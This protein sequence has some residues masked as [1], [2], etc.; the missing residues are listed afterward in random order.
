MT[1]P[2]TN[3]EPTDSKTS[4]QP[5]SIADA[6]KKPL[7]AFALLFA[8][9]AVFGQLVPKLIFP[10]A[11]PLQAERNIQTE[12]PVTTLTAAPPP[13]PPP[14]APPPPHH[15]GDTHHPVGKLHARIDKL[16]AQL[17]AYEELLTAMPTPSEMNNELVASDARIVALEKKLEGL[18]QQISQNAVRS[19]ELI[20]AFATLSKMR[21]AAMNGEKF[22]PQY[23]RFMELN[24]TNSSIQNM[25]L[26]LS[27]YTEGGVPTLEQLQTSF[28]K[29]VPKALSPH[30]PT[31]VM[32][33]LQSLVTIRKVGDQQ[34][35]SDEAILARAELLLKKG[36]L[37]LAKEEMHSLSEHA[38]AIFAD[39]LGSVN[40][41]LQ[42]KLVFDKLQLMLSEEPSQPAKQAPDRV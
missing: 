6:L 41:R 31:S 7:I 29:L 24:A 3:E 30:E 16:E 18:E 39:W 35:N 23:Q 8:V 28:D 2:E 26:Q 38:A 15:M 25:M 9:W 12:Q 14:P 13:P 33:N 32:A 10:K 4:K 40:T 27:N 42:T 21:Q 20:E 19:S 37:L 22:F 34:G 1:Q 36:Q 11:K 5:A 17:Q